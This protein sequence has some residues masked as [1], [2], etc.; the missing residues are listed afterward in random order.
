MA[1]ALE[2]RAVLSAETSAFNRDMKRAGDAT[3]QFSNTATTKTRPALNSM[4]SGMSN[5]MGSFG[6]FAKFAGPAGVVVAAIGAT[7]LAF[8]KLKQSIAQ[9]VGA[10]RRAMGTLDAFAKMTD[11]LGIAP[12]AFQKISLAARLTADITE[13]QLSVA[14]QRMTRRVAE[15]ANGS[16]ELETALN[17]LG[18]SGEEL[19]RLSPDQQFLKLADGMQAINN[20]S[21]RVRLTFKI[22]DTEGVALVNT[23]SKG[24][25]ALQQ[26]GSDIDEFGLALD[27]AE[28]AQIEAANDAWTLMREIVGGVINRLAVEFA[29]VVEGIAAAFIEMLGGIDDAQSGFRAFADLAIAVLPELLNQFAMLA[30]VALQAAAGIQILAAAIA[31]PVIGVKGF[32]RAVDAAMS[33]GKFGMDLAMKG[34][35]GTPGA[36]FTDAVTASRRRASQESVMITERSFEGRKLRVQEDTLDEIRGLRREQTQNVTVHS[37][38]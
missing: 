35:E 16:K 23:L 3:K 28:L 29:P 18:T 5:V 21:E 31:I 15:A 8:R 14:M 1:S 26:M 34:V 20:Q 17:Q 19:I 36:A 6:A 12:E 2:M 13:E 27:R 10:V 22:F 37:L 33:M 38:F 11:K 25:E 9:I 24:S 7:T 32:S 30:G 4:R